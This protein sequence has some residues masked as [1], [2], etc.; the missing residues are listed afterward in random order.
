MPGGV[1]GKGMG[2]LGIDWAITLTRTCMLATKASKKKKTKKDKKKKINKKINKKEKK[3]SVTSSSML[4]NSFLKWSLY[5]ILHGLETWKF[6]LSLI[7]R[8]N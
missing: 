7:R 6:M 8:R 2:T 4:A 1:G 5:V 3:S